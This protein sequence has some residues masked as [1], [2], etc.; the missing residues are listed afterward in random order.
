MY[1]FGQDHFST[2]HFENIH[3]HL[4]NTIGTFSNHFTLC[5][6]IKVNGVRALISKLF[7]AQAISL[8]AFQSWM[9]YST[10]ILLTILSRLAYLGLKI[11]ACVLD[12][13][14]L[15][16]SAKVYDGLEGI[17]QLSHFP[18]NC[19]IGPIS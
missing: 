16:S 12:C 1:F 2:S 10:I 19:Q 14:C 17:F 15:T 5:I 13:S 3:R 9:K 11:T 7:I 18:S 6:I 8:R 4:L